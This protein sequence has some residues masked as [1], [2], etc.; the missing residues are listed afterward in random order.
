MCDPVPYKFKALWFMF[1]H[2]CK[3]RNKCEAK[4]QES[5]ASPVETSDL[6]C[7][8]MTVI[9]VCLI[10]ACPPVKSP[11][12]KPQNSA[13]LFALL[14]PQTAV[15]AIFV[16]KLLW[17]HLLLKTIIILIVDK[18]KNYFSIMTAFF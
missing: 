6:F 14:S 18:L 3:I 11:A 16:E 8:K 15:H 17:F 1:F 10:F 13:Y 5:L 9:F 2:Y 12:L 4:S 7:S